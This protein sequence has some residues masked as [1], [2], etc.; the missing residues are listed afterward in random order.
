MEPTHG[1]PPAHSPGGP[2]PDGSRKRGISAT[3]KEMDLLDPNWP[4][5]I[6]QGN[7]EIMKILADMYPLVAHSSLLPFVEA[8]SLV[9]D[10]LARQ[11]AGAGLTQEECV[12]SALKEGKQAYLQ[13][14]ITNISTLTRDVYRFSFE[15]AVA[16]VFVNEYSGFAV[17]SAHYIA[18]AELKHCISLGLTLAHQEVSDEIANRY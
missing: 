3:R 11:D 5:R 15:S 12:A 6:E 13:R 2:L 18:F 4:R 7:Q 17:V 8:Y 1:C 16:L 9:F 10:L 14:R